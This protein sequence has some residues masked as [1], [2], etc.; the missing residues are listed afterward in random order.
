MNFS[1]TAQEIGELSVDVN[2]IIGVIKEDTEDDM[3]LVCVLNKPLVWIRRNWLFSSITSVEGT[4]NRGRESTF[5]GGRQ[6]PHI[7]NM[8]HAHNYNKPS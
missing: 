4:Q 7:H 2:E 6:L 1:F 5:G 3:W 8:T